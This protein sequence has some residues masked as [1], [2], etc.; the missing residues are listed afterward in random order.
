VAQCETQFRTGDGHTLQCALVLDATDGTL[1]GAADGSRAAGMR[2]E[3]MDLARALRLVLERPE[4]LD[5]WLAG[6]VSLMPAAAG[7]P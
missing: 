3:L 7:D 6:G 5:E 4:A 2:G 1:C